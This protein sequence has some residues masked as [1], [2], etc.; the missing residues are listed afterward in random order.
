MLSD[1]TVQIIEQITPAVAAKAEHYP[2]VGKHLLDAIHDVMG[3]RHARRSDLQP[4][5][6]Q[7]QRR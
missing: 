7:S 4:L 5:A 6:R 3:G 2:I 1:K